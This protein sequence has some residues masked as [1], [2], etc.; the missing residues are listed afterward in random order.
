MIVPQLE[1][2][3]KIMAPTV[4]LAGQSY[5]YRRRSRSLGRNTAAGRNWSSSGR[6]GNAQGSRQPATGMVSDG[7][8]RATLAI[9]NSRPCPAASKLGTRGPQRWTAP[10]IGNNRTATPVRCLFD[11]LR[12]SNTPTHIRCKILSPKS[13]DVSTCLHSEEP[14]SILGR[15]QRSR[16]PARKRGQCRHPKFTQFPLQSRVC[17]AQS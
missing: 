16:R 10:G 11:A 8:L 12:T 4:R 15:E 2:A 3:N 5:Q 13:M 1:D 6:P 17:Q 9:G 14:N 7:P